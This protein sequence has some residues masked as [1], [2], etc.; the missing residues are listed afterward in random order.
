MEQRTEPLWLENMSPRQA[1]QYVNLSP[2]FLA[3]MRMRS[4]PKQGP[5][6]AKIGKA[7]VYRRSDLDQW[8]AAHVVE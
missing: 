4:G 1:A 3:K 8:L 2:S 6:Y 7:V 5:R